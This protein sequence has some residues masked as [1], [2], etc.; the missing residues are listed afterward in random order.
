MNALNILIEQHEMS[1][2]CPHCGWM[3]TNTLEWMS[4]HRD[5]KCPACLGVIVLNT[6]EK[7]REIANFRRQALALAAQ[8]S[9]SI[10]V[11][12]RP[13]PAKPKLQLVIADLYGGNRWHAM[14]ERTVR[15][16]RNRR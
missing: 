9:D 11:I 16:A 5:T 1:I 8:L 15:V 10:P 13:L 7:R 2:E 6:T 12:L 4:A 3:G 14:N